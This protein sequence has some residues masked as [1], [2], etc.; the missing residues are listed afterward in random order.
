MIGFLKIYVLLNLSVALGFLAHSFLVFLW[1]DSRRQTDCRQVSRLA[2]LLF[3]SALLVP[4][5]SPQ[6]EWKHVGIPTAFEKPLSES[7][8]LFEK[9]AEA[10]ENKVS[11]E[12]SDKRESL[13]FFHWERFTFL[14]YI[15]LFISLSVGLGFGIVRKNLFQLQELL[16]NSFLVRRHRTLRVSISDRVD[17]PFSAWIWGQ[18]WIVVPQTLVMDQAKYRLCLAHE[19]EHHRAWDTVWTFFLEWLSP[20]FLLNPFF[21]FWKMDLSELQEFACDETLIG[22]RRLLARKY[23]SCLLEVAEAA[24]CSRSKLH[25]VSAMANNRHSNT[26]LERRITMLTKYTHQRPKSGSLLFTT[27]LLSTA[28]MAFSVSAKSVFAT[29]T[30]ESPNSGVAQV[31]PVVQTLTESIL[32]EAIGKFYATSGFALVSE[33]KTGRLLAVANID[34]DPSTPHLPH[35]ALS[36]RIEPASVIKALVAAAAIEEGVTRVD[37]K[38]NCENGKL[39]IENKEYGDW[40]A[41]GQLTTAE[42]IAQ[43]SNICGI[44]IGR[45]LGAQGIDGFLKRFGFGPEGVTAQFPEARA[46]VLPSIDSLGEAHYIG[47]LS[48]GFNLY[49]TP[50]EIVQAFGAIA[51]GGNLLAPQQASVGANAEPKV[52]RR[53]LSEQNAKTAREILQGVTASRGTAYVARSKRIQFGGKTG[54]GYSQW[55][56]DTNAP[57]VKESQIAHFV[58]MAPIESP[59][60][61]VYVGIQDPKN[62][63]DQKAHGSEHAA[64]VARDILEKLLLN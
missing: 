49:T 47:G 23:G 33:V 34:P 56:V 37:E 43:S 27:I 31:D 22:R 29:N 57:A 41:F 42:A 19:L 51:N 58:G 63:P 53:V 6:F 2:R 45:K 8:R 11:L 46:G 3:A 62:S 50:L 35:W 1:K 7:I 24:L 39:L 25:F 32:M 64:P 61:V 55:L 10:I 44:K 17:V 15:S 9:K 21:S 12:N 38:H 14:E 59:R 26:L 30:K 18:C 16:K 52:L 60:Y 13:S 48:S 20:F 54:T 4:V 36:L 5:L 28:L 40:K